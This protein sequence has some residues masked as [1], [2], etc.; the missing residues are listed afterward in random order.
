MKSETLCDR[1]ICLDALLSFDGFVP[2]LPELQ[3]KAVNFLELFSKTLIS[4][5]ENEQLSDDLCHAFCC[6]LDRRIACCL[7]TDG[8]AWERYSLTRYF[9]GYQS[10]E[11]TLRERLAP[12][13]AHAEGQIFNYARKLLLTAASSGNGHDL[14]KLRSLYAP[15]SPT[16]EWQEKEEEPQRA[17][18][19]VR[20]MLPLQLVLLS[21]PLIAL[22]FFCISYLDAL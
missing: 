6:Y 15:P 19:P 20:F 11:K 4:E 3:L 14:E 9:Y 17:P 1:L 18:A 12:L 2:S 21:L 5:G 16:V 13:L 22:W 10:E 8:K 7:R